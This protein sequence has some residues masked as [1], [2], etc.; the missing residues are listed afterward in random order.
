MKN[1]NDFDRRFSRTETV[2]NI[3]FVFQIIFG[4]VILAGTVYVVW[5]LFHNP[6]AIGEFF[7]NI[8]KG[9]NQSK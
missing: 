8:A 3:I 9:F 7:G 5:Y 6:Q 1:F 2:F 4:L